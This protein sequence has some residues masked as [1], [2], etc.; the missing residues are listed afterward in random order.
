M[1]DFLTKDSGEREQFQSGMQRDTQK[2][3]PRY[4]LI[5]RAF[6][7]R[8]AELMA[9]GAEKYGEE[10]WRKAE[11]EKEL[12]RFQ[13]SAIRHLFQWLEGDTSEDHAVAVAFNISGAEMVKDKMKSGGCPCDLGL[14]PIGSECCCRDCHGE[15][16]LAF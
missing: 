4:D 5:D 10:N 8:W 12:S 1:S 16:G 2:G 9:R 14:P 6:L 15:E 13:A 3:K 11:G 7:K